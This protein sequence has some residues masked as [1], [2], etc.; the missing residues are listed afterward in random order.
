MALSTFRIVQGADTPIQ[1]ELFKRVDGKPFALT[2]I[3]S[4]NI[5]LKNADDSKLTKAMTVDDNPGG[6]LS[7]TLSAAETALLKAGDGLSFEVELNYASSVKKVVPFDQILEVK[8]R[9]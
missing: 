4:A 2:N 3:V 8:K 5:I 6:K 9:I 7:V 1:I